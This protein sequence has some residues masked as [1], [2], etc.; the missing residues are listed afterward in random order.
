MKN[1]FLISNLN[2]LYAYFGEKKNLITINKTKSLLNNNQKKG[3]NK[4]IVCIR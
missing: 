2:Q 3:K 4:K 1:S